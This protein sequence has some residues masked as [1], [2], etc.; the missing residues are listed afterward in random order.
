MSE[1]RI[2]PRADVKLEIQY[3]PVPEFLGGVEASR[4]SR[5]PRVTYFDQGTR[6]GQDVL[7][8]LTGY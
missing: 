2:Q 7:H 3:Q 6:S 5:E 1:Q 8:M 4:A